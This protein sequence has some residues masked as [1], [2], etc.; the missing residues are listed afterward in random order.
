MA[1]NV[2]ERLATLRKEILRHNDLYYNNDSPEITDYQYDQLMLEL[3][4]LEKEHPELVTADSPTQ[5]VGGVAKRTAGILVRHDVPMLSL[6]DVFSKEDIDEFVDAILHDM[7]DCEFVVEEK[8]DGLSLALRYYNGVL[9]TA[10][11]RGDGIVEGEDVTANALNLRGVSSTLPEKLPYLEVRG[12]VYMTREAF[13]KVNK[14]QLENDKKLFANPRNC[15]AGTLRQLDSNVIKKR[16]LSIFAF[17]LQKAE[18]RLF[19]KHDETLRYFKEQGIPII[20]DYVVCKTKQEVWQ[21][22][23]AIE[24]R[25][26][27]L[28]YD[29]DGAVVKVNSLAQREILGATSKVPRWA[30]AYKYPPEEKDTKLLAIKLSVGRTGRITPTAIFEPVQ[31][32][33]T[34]VERATLHN[35]DFID[36]L[37]IRVGD[38][39]RVYKSG[40]IIPK[41]R[42][43]LKTKRTAAL[44]PFKIGNKCPVCGAPAIRDE[45]TADVRCTNSSCPAQFEGRLVNF[46]G[47]GAMDIKGFGEKYIKKLIDEGYLHDIADIYYLREQRDELVEK[48]LIGKD[49]NTD[50]LLEKIEVSKTNAPWRLLAGFG[51]PNIGKAAA[52]SLMAYFHTIDA[53]AAADVDTIKQVDDIGDVSAKFV[54]EF[55]RGKENL[56]MLDKLKKAGM[57]M[58]ESKTVTEVNDNVSDRTFVLT[59]TLSTMSRTE[60]SAAIEKMG[61]RVVSSVSA[62]TDYVVVGENAGSKL[63]K[64][65][66]LGVKTLS[67]DEF[68]ALLAE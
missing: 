55:F 24:K 2:K 65:Q 38:I 66:K 59:G 29:I 20:H 6:Q 64:A 31:L 33:G 28:P 17:N 23:E 60:A 52:K 41:I 56:V 44:Q 51:I 15:A 53:L 30:V 9:K 18:G 26:N 16:G 45:N 42:C 62:K 35:Q 61:G 49:K 36:A 25:R 27:K 43:V 10:I 22:I 47:R 58:N 54:F 37:D 4:K 32:C 7:P 46:V 48:G 67:E 63:V 19:T 50:K 1:E 14:E 21:A 3:K 39:I 8:I 57:N 13:E 40:E 34:V 11:T 5:R 68:R 12:E